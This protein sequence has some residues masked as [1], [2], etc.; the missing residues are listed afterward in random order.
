MKSII[1]TGASSG[2]GR[3]TAL[4]LASGGWHVALSGRDHARLNE[5][6]E[7]CQRNA[8]QHG[9]ST[10]FFIHA[11]SFDQPDQSA[12]ALIAAS[13]DAF[14]RLDAIVNCA[15]TLLK[16][17]VESTRAQDF[18]EVF[19]VNTVAP[20]MLIAHGWKYLAMTGTGSIVNVSSLASVDPFEGY[21][22]YA[23]SKAALDSLTRSAAREGASVG[24]RVW[25][26]LPGSI[27][28]PMLRQHTPES[29]LPTSRTL[30]ADAVAEVIESCLDG[31][32]DSESG[33]MIV[34]ASP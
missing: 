11:A 31:R 21:F 23:A 1:V 34:V 33:S 8:L 25:S 16:R 5:T 27:E 24:I 6:L 28:T 22:A 29:V 32:R 7:Q 10:R 2:I 13:V 26:I 9:H 3:A 14:G 18:D 20:A 12:R 4:R 19:A 30:P 15:G 17:S